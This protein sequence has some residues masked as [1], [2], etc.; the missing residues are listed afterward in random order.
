MAT[1]QVAVGIDVGSLMEGGMDRR[2]LLELVKEL[3]E[4][5]GDWSFTLEL[6]DHFDKLRAEHAKEEAEDA[7]KREATR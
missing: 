7:A 3:D 6:A 4:A 5:M 1:I 2:D